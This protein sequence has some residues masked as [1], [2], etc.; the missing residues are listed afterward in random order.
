MKCGLRL[1]I[2]TVSYVHKSLQPTA[3]RFNIPLNDAFINSPSKQTFDVED[4]SKFRLS[5]NQRKHEKESKC[6]VELQG[7]LKVAV[8]LKF[9]LL[10]EML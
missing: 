6:N 9:Y 2:C 4:M 8:F 5:F 3:L 7:D 10:Y 1:L